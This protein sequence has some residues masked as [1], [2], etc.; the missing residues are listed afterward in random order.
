MQLF[1]ALTVLMLQNDVDLNGTFKRWKAF[2]MMC[3]TSYQLSPVTPY[4]DL[5]V[6]LVETA[7]C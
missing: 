1:K 2:L 4:T 3:S 7:V 5:S 6:L